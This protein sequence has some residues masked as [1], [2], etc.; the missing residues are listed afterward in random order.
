MA[1][2]PPVSA[3]PPSTWTY[4]GRI[5]RGDLTGIDGPAANET[6]LEA[7]HHWLAGRDVT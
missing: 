2:R 1:P 6:G 3:S 7:A 4:A 5:A